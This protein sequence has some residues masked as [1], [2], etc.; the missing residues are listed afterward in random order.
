MSLPAVDRL[1]AHL[2]TPGAKPDLLKAELL[3]LI[4]RAITNH[5]RSLQVQIGP[6][7]V[8]HACPRRIGYKLL[9]HP[10]NPGEPNWKATVGTAIHAWLEEVMITDNRARY[11]E[12]ADLTRWIVEATVDCGEVLGHPITGHCDLFDRVTGT[13][14]DW[15]TCG[16]TQLKKYKAKGPGPQYRTQAHL[17][18][19]GWQHRGQ[20]VHHVGVMFLPRNGDLREAY[21]WSEP[22]DE[23]VALDGLQRLEGIALAARHLGPAVLEQLDTADAFC[24]MC[25]YYKAN[26]TD[27]TVGC[28]GDPGVRRTQPAPALT[29]IN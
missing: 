23:Q 11:A 16:P 25:P 24:S 1:P 14:V 4:T 6:S 28:P 5:P 22:Y 9:G 20:D 7:E 3:D 21:Y 17:Y 26:S 8:G 18:G 2:T 27:V 29:L 13:V 12:L 10:E 15:K 19:R